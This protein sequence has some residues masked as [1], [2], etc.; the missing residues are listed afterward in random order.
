MSRW[1]IVMEINK[2]KF[3]YC[4][5]TNLLDDNIAYFFDI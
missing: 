1:S 5:K 3:Q 2:L 4:I